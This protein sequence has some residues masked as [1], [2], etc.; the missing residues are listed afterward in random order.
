MIL[1]ITNAFL[2][3][4]I[5]KVVLP[6]MLH[7]RFIVNGASNERPVVCISF[8]CE[9]SDD[10]RRI[11]SLLE[12]LKDNDISTSFAIRGDLLE[13]HEDVVRELLK[14][15]HEIINHTFVHPP[16]F[17]FVDAERM[18]GEVEFFQ[19]L[20]KRRFGYTPE[21][22]RAPHLMRRYNEVLFRILRENKLYDSSYVGS[23]V[24][25]IDGVVEIP[26]TACPDHPQVCYDYW[27]HFQLPLVKSSV[28]EFFRL[29][30]CLLGTR[31]LTNV[32]LDPHLVSDGFLGEMI[33]LVPD[34]YRFCRLKDVVYSM[35]G[36]RYTEQ[37]DSSSA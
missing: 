35:S 29:W 19:V 20:M 17:A 9:N 1:R 13:Q 7:D 28:K 10:M 27:H 5:L 23:G 22:F 8:D 31:R 26:L 32:F 30:G 21:G 12:M 4:H 6:L 24:S 14:N 37:R 16:K 18:R 11:P 34:D 25:L 15:G 3:R 2:H 33:A 36:N